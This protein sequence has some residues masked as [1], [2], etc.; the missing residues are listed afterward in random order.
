MSGTLRRVE[1]EVEEGVVVP[2]QRVRGCRAVPTSYRSRSQRAGD[3]TPVASAL[4]TPSQPRRR[5]WAPD[6]LID[7]YV[8][9]GIPFHFPDGWRF[10]THAAVAEPA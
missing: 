6:A 3:P 10:E 4:A 8:E 7:A 5:W 1:R 2:Y 9:P